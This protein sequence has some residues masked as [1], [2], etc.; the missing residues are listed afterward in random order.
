M[1][2]F[3]PEQDFTLTQLWHTS[4]IALAGY[5]SGRYDRLCWVARE[6]DKTH[7]GE[8]MAAYKRVADITHGY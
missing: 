8:R 6:W 1:I 2:S 7:P 4:R 5:A 3:T